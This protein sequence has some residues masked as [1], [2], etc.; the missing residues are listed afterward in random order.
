MNHCLPHFR[1]RTPGKGQSG[2]TLVEMLV[3]LLVFGIIASVATALVTTSSRSFARSEQALADLG[4]LET[5]RMTLAADL[6]Q[7][8]ARP[9][10][11][12]DGGRLPAFVLMPQGLVLVRRGLSHQL[13]AIEKIAWGF[14]GHRLL[15]Q[16]FPAL[17]GSPPGRAVVM[18][19]DVTAIKLRV[20]DDRGWQTRWEPLQPESLPRAIELTVQRTSSP[21]V[22]LRFTVGA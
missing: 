5:M 13:P 17:D 1:R 15:R 8:A 18:V 7:A 14:D 4:S 3:A 19:N 21:P 20:A 2:F 6:G 12:A 16:T 9:S 10:I 11:A 22:T